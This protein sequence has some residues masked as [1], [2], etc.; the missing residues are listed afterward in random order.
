[1]HGKTTIKAMIMFYNK[2]RVCRKRSADN[3][4]DRSVCPQ[5]G[6]AMCTDGLQTQLGKGDV[7]GRITDTI[8]EGFGGKTE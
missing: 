3:R 8:R 1:M 5:G 7:Q 4:A 6:R 2:I